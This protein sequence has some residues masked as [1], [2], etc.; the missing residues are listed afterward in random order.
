MNHNEMLVETVELKKYFELGKNICLKNKKILKAVDGINLKLYGGEI[1]GLVGESGCGKST[2]GRTILNLYPATSGSVSYRGKAPAKNDFKSMREIREKLQMIFQDP[3]ASLNPRMTIFESIRAPLDV[4]KKGSGNERQERVKTIA[5]YV[6]LDRANLYKFPHE[7]SG[8][9]RQRAVIARAMILEPD[10]IICDEPVSAL[11]MSIRSQILN[12]MKEM[13]EEKHLAYLFISHDLSV[14]RY[15]CDRVAIMYLG[16]IIEEGDK[17]ELFQNPV[18]PYTQALLSA[19]PIP[20]VDVRN[21]RIILQGDVPSP[22]NPP[23]GCRFYTR[24]RYAQKGCAKMEPELKELSKSHQ[25][26]CWHSG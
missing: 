6:G 21:K 26:A 24:C 7:M 8:G 11:D 25:V 4:Y 9:Q 1:L 18:H 23:A 20:D 22:I 10:L 17:E 16:K 14:I 19:V 15:L 13:Q 2:L 3:L 5:R 12:L